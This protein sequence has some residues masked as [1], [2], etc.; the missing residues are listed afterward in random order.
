MQGLGGGEEGWGYRGST[1]REEVQRWWGPRSEEVSAEG[2]ETAEGPR[3]VWGGKRE[4]GDLRGRGGGKMR[5][6]APQ[7]AGEMQRGREMGRGAGR[8]GRRSG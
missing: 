5:V 6:G 7:G 8:W 1:L 2:G 3:T 4:G